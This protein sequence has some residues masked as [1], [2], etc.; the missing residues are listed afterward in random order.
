[1]Y[2]TCT[3]NGPTLSFLQTCARAHTTTEVPNIMLYSPG[4]SEGEQYFF[5]PLVHSIFLPRSLLL[6]VKHSSAGLFT[7]HCS[8]GVEERKGKDEKKLERTERLVV[9]ERGGRK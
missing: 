7:G 9:K 6:T 2:L 8:R 5:L 1:M 4:P 3:L